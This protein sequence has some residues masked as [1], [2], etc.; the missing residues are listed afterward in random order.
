MANAAT[1]EAESARADARDADAAA[2]R[3]RVRV[4][5]L[6]AAA[7]VAGNTAA[8]GTSS[9]AGD[10]L[11]VLANM[12]SRLDRRAG[13]LAGYA[14]AA[15]IAGQACERSYDALTGGMKPER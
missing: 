5:Q 4:A 8:P 13:E 10:P 1:K 2:E 12:F 9:A 14:D 7:R 3:L 6:I 15:R 11:D